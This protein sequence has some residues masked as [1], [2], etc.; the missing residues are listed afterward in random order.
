MPWPERERGADGTAPRTQTS[1]WPAGCYEH[2]DT[3]RARQG[4]SR[5]E[6][7][8]AVLAHR[9]LV[10]DDWRSKEVDAALVLLLDAAARD[11][12]LAGVA[13]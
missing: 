6:S 9:V 7:A 13:P 11:F 8:T 2:Q 12:Q 1:A 5:L 4:A 3:A 10:D